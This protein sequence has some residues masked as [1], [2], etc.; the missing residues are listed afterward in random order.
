[1]TKKASI[2]QLDPEILLRGTPGF[3][4]WILSRFAYIARRRHV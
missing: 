2:E 1:M 3:L 4:R